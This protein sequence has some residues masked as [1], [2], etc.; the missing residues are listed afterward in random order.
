M[1]ISYYFF[2]AVKTG[3]TYD[4]TYSASD[5]ARYFDG[6]VGSGVFPIPSTSLQV[7][8]GTGMQVIVGEG[9]GWIEGHKMINDA[10]LTLAIDAADVTLNRIDRVVFRVNVTNRL[11]EIVVK[12]GTNASSP[13]AP[14][15]VRNADMIEYS[16]ATIRVNRQ[17]T[18]ITASMI[19]D[20]RLDSTVCG[21][22]QG[23]IQQVDT[24]TLYQQ[25][26]AGYEEALEDLDGEFNTW[27]NSIKSTIAENVII[28]SYRNRTV[29]SSPTTVLSIGISNY[30]KE[31]DIL[32]VYVSGLRLDNTE[33]TVNEAGNAVTFTKQLDSGAVVEFVVYKTIDNSDAESAT[34]MVSGLQTEVEEVKSSVQTLGAALSE[35][36]S[37]YSG[38]F[39][40]QA[41]STARYTTINNLSDY[42]IIIIRCKIG[43][44]A[45]DDKIYFKNTATDGVI[46]DIMSVYNG[47]SYYGLCEFICDFA[48]NR[49]GVRARSATGW[50]VS[51]MAIT[52]V[53]GI[54]L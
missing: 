2:D 51:T 10:D 32:D 16:L 48:S 11:M 5:F 54:K 24:S 37:L 25:W 31:L 20:T 14:A 38:T 9:M 1:A 33:Y 40:A 39:A 35:P 53:W 17:T 36:T 30:V 46:T 34:T 8:A 27:F 6:L 49:V 21:M 23:L 52:G 18:A 44:Y 4:R 3:S 28:K 13:T 50:T 47:E 19:T 12:K 7:R 15:I 45:T 26:Q 22:V 41:L 42:D 29:T 43:S